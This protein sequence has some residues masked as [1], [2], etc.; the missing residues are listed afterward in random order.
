VAVS[1]LAGEPDAYQ[2]VIASVDVHTGE[3]QQLVADADYGFGA[4]FATGLL[5]EP[6]VPGIEPPRPLDPRLVAAGGVLVVVAAL[7]AL[8]MW[9][10]RVQP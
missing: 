3:T 7:A 1:L 6:T 2:V 10:R 8:I 9:R 5:A 4:Q